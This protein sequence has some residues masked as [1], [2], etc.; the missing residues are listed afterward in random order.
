MR[1]ILSYVTTTLIVVLVCI[2]LVIINVEHLFMS[3]YYLYIFL[4][5]ISVWVS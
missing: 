1:A 4:G 2:S 5:E 3:L